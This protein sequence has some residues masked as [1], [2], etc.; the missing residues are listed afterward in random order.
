MWNILGSTI[1]P[2]GLTVDEEALWL[3]IPEIERFDRKQAKVRLTRD[4]VEILH[5]LGMKV[6]GFWAE[7]F[8]SVEA[9]F[10]YATTCRLFWVQEAPEGD[11]EGGGNG[12]GV[13]GG[14]EGRRKLK[15]NDRRR[16]NSRPVYRRWIT[17]FIP[18]L[19]AKGQF[20][21]SEPGASVDHV[22]AAVR[23]EAFVRFFVEA[24]YKKRLK[25]W[26]LKRDT[27]EMKSLI[28]CLVPDTLEPQFRSCLV[29]ALRKIVME[30]DR[31]LGITPSSPL[32]DADGFYDVE[33]VR[34]FVQDTWQQVGELAWSRQKQKAA[35]AMRLKASR[36]TTGKAGS[37]D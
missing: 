9:L 37:E 11:A 5:F 24:E 14:E 2:Y 4:P 15:S 13:V 35:E 12:V 21:R 36:K 34:S 17:E 6:D 30:D 16:M 31:T 27:D 25:D 29:A 33:G 19:R 18:S 23:D 8:E 1:R 7:P 28:K 26:L 3:R 32:R 20:M 22:R 10:D